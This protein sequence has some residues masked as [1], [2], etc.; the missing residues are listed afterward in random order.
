MFLVSTS[1][2]SNEYLFPHIKDSQGH[3]TRALRATHP[4]GG[5]KAPID[6]IAILDTSFRKRFF[7]PVGARGC[8][9]GSKGFI[10]LNL[11]DSV[12]V[13]DYCV[14]YLKAEQELEDQFES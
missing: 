4:M 14:R 9:P 5:G 8:P 12:K 13:I 2:T 10:P 1:V 3:L 7:A 11:L 6:S